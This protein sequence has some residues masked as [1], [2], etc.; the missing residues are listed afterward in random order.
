MKTKLVTAY[1]MD[2]Q[3]YP[4]Q[5]A[6]PDRKIRYQGSLISHCIGSNLPVICYTHSRNY[7]EL[8]EIKL[9]YNLTN[10][11]LKILELSDVKYHGEIDKIRNSQ[12]NT[13]LD[14]RGPEIMWGKFDVLEREL[15]G[16]D[17][18]YWVDVGLQHPGI[19]PWM[20]SKVYDP[21]YSDLNIPKNWWAHLDVFNFSKL[22]DSEIYTQLD[23]ICDN[24]I[25]FVCSYGPQIGYPFVQEGI[26]EHPFESPYPVGGMFGGDVKILKKYI[27][28]CWEF[29]EKILD[30]NILCTEEVIMKPSYNLIPENERVTLIFN[31][32][33]SGE[34]DDF[35]YRMWDEEKNPLKPF[36]MMWKDI[37]NFNL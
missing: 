15:D 37:K 22:I 9:N 13:D 23:K 34:H 16:F 28:I 33:A 27:D 4:Y 11:E 20:Y 1:W 21:E 14:G 26:L 32:F 8:N 17:R 12:F 5:G 29:T 25:M 3:G 35:H 2:A 7:D 10:L 24:K 36:Y 19:F 31:S 6:N 18:V 30:K